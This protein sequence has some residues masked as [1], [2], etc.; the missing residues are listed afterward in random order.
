MF[1]SNKVMFLSVMVVLIIATFAFTAYAS[2]SENPIPVEP[3]ELNS[4]PNSQD[5]SLHIIDRAS[6]PTQNDITGSFST[7]STT[8]PKANRGYI[9]L[10]YIRILIAPLILLAPII[11]IIVFVV[12][13]LRAGSNKNE[14]FKSNFLKYLIWAGIVFA[15][16]IAIWYLV[17]LAPVW[18]HSR[19]LS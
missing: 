4:Q 9:L 8:I 6:L 11:I 1:K 15:I 7:E 16:G 17:T 13:W 10:N 14:W 12:K 2:V 5:N 19:I 3:S 18:M